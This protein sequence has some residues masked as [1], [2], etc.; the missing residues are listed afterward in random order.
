MYQI[1]TWSTACC[2]WRL[3]KKLNFKFQFEHHFAYKPSRLL[4]NCKK[5]TLEMFEFLNIMRDKICKIHSF[6]YHN[7]LV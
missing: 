3:E 7:L 6:F 4:Y 1:L 2:I 5:L